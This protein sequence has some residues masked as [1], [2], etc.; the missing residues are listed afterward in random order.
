MQLKLNRVY[1]YVSGSLSELCDSANMC[2]IIDRCACMAASVFQR[3]KVG[4]RQVMINLT[5]TS[6]YDLVFF[7]SVCVCTGS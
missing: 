2:S 5:E 3:G 4:G 6:I 1:L 7:T